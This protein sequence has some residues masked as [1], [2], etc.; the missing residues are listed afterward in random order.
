MRN[1]Y[2]RLTQLSHL[3]KLFNTKIYTKI[4]G[5]KQ[6]TLYQEILKSRQCQPGLQINPLTLYF[7]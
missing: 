5:I 1:V 6:L 4:N 2:Y 3:K 7:F